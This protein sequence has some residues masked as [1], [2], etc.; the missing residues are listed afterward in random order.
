MFSVRMAF[1][2][3][4]L[5]VFHHPLANWEESHERRYTFRGRRSRLRENRE[6]KI[7]KQKNTWLSEGWTDFPKMKPLHAAMYF[8]FFPLP[9]GN[10]LHIA[11]VF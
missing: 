9:A 3:S 8:S 11:N 6:A 5:G 4:A 10:M 1:W 2:D 7:E